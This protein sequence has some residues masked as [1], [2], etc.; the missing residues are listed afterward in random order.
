MG[1]LNPA[2]YA[3]GESSNYAACFHDITNGNNFSPS[4]SN[5]FAAVPG[6]DLCSG[7]G[8][9]AGQALINALE[10][11][12]YLAVTPQSDITAFGL[13]GG[14]FYP[15]SETYAVSN[16]GAATLD[17]ILSTDAGWLTVFPT[18]G[19]SAAESRPVSVQATV[20][21]FCRC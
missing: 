15:A 20:N 9:P 21:T 7:W 16:A 17:W 3:I 2:L 6:F 10:P 18:N 13:A 12:D 8:S 11:Q 4:S 19:T 14:P 5:L 1:F